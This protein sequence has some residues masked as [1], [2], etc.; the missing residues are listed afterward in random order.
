MGCPFSTRRC[1][2]RSSCRARVGAAA[3]T[4]TGDVAEL[5]CRPGDRPAAGDLS[6]SLLHLA[7]LGELVAQ[8]RRARHCLRVCSSPCPWGQQF[9]GW[10]GCCSQPPL[11]TAVHSAECLMGSVLRIVLAVGLACVE[12]CAW[13]ESAQSPSLCRGGPGG[14]P[15]P[16]CP[17]RKGREGAQ[18][19]RGAAPV[20]LLRLMPFISE[21]L[22]RVRAELEMSG[23]AAG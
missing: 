18:G 14:T 7:E 19:W 9:S 5:L 23:T 8:V 3:Q 17:F 20:S 11:G 1:P 16:G 10:L 12:P 21:L 13:Q 22:A 4:C 6:W 2:P 15:V